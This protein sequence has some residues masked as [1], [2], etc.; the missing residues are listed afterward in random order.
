MK[1][2]LVVVDSIDSNHSSGSKANLAFIQN[3]ALAG[4]GVKVLHYSNKEIPLS[5]IETQLI[6]TQKLSITYFLSRF[7]RV[8]TRITKINI[9]PTVE[10]WF[11][12]SFTFFNDVKSMH[13]ALKKESETSYD[14]LL[15]LSY[16]SSFRP[17]AAVLR[18]SRF[19]NKW[20]AYVH[21]PYP[22]HSYP[23]PYDWVEPGHQYKRNFFLKIAKYTKKVLYPSQ[24]L[25]EWMEQYYEDLKNKRVIVPHQNYEQEANEIPVSSPYIDSNYFT[26]LHS[27]SLMDARNPFGLIKGYTQ[28]IDENPEAK[29]DS[30][31]IFIGIYSNFHQRIQKIQ[32]DYP[33]LVLSDG[34]VDFTT[35]LEIQKRA[36]VNIILEAIAYFS[37]FL[38]GKF[39]HCIQAQKP[40]LLI[41]PYFSESRRLLGLDYKYWSE[42]TDSFRIKTLITQLYLEWKDNK[43]GIYARP[44]LEYY[45]SKDHLKTIFDQL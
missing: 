32:E 22:M 10:K 42:N 19:H 45:L 18:Q 23:R 7:Q 29:N 26:L 25:A 11:G 8:F 27:G 43:N 33:S 6:S 41:G 20:L 28:F 5:G 9:N 2:I 13:L 37:P 30:K 35:T 4:F 14:W 15:T 17:H 21:D 12:F 31:L 40:I 34:Y 3:L 39:T 24:Y 16:A 1:K 38:P 44:D 36:N